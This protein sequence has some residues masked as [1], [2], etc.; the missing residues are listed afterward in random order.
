MEK[1]EI[2]HIIETFG[3]AVCDYPFEDDFETMILRH[4]ATRKWFGAYL[5]VPKRIFGEGEK[6]EEFALDIKCDPVLAKMLCETY[7]G[8]VPG[9]HM[10]KTHWITVRLDDSVPAGETEKLLRL[11]YD[12]VSPKSRANAKKQ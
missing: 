5:R 10:N 7:K 4:T 8:I 3:N 11:G 12:L 9:Y 2:L 6:G 1:Q